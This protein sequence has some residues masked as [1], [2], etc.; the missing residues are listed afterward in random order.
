M[1]ASKRILLHPAQVWTNGEIHR[2]W[3]VLV[4]G[5]RVAAVGSRE[6]VGRPSDCETIELPDATLLPGL[7]DLHSHLFLHP[8]NET[9]WDDQVLKETE[10]YRTLRAG[11]HA[12]AT[13]KAGFT[14]LRDLGTEG[15]GYADVSLKRAIEEGIVKGPRLFV[16]GRAI[17]A[18]GS[19]GPARKNYRHDCCFPQGAVEA[20]GVEEIVRAV[21]LE[22]AYGADWIK[23]YGDYRTGPVGEMR[24]TFCE[25]ELRAAVS[26]AHDL[27]RPVAVHAMTD[28][29]MHR[30]AS[31]GV[32]TIEHGYGGSRETFALM[33][34]KGVAFLPTLA[35][36]EAISEY[37]RGDVPG[38]SDSTE[39]MQMAERGFRNA[40]AE[41]VT[42]GCG[43]DVGVFAHG[44]NVRE[45]VWMT[46]LGMTPAQA[47]LAATSANAKIL[48]KAD[49]LGAIKQGCLADL[50]AVEGDPTSDNAA[51]KN[52]RLV[53][54]NG[55]IYWRP[56]KS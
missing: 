7:M 44:T 1:A 17:A 16:S 2:G 36:P 52:V 45:L 31:A 5:N 11:R 48:G 27:G 49:E 8:Y 30:A 23:I 53:M 37:F 41:G 46:R 20:S 33:R 22:A 18:T 28:E 14:T 12:E 34:E 42:I 56:E 35:A 3:S 43:S 54:K 51:L 29:A 50:I 38:Q 9:S 15:A 21:R 26:V 55:T 47:L 25:E 6:A 4:E 10:A 24:P 39:S 40:L 19:Y 13:L 32:Q